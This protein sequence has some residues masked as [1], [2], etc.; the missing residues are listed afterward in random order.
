[1]K[2][3]AFA[4]LGGFAAQAKLG[5]VSL[6]HSQ[7]KEMN[8]GPCDYGDDRGGWGPD[9]AWN[10]STS[11]CPGQFGPSCTTCPNSW[12][13]ESG[14]AG[15]GIPRECSG[16]GTCDGSG[17]LGGTGVCTCAPGYSGGGCELGPPPATVDGP[18]G[19]CPGGITNGTCC[20]CT[21]G[22]GTRC[23]GYHGSATWNKAGFKGKVCCGTRCYTEPDC[24]VGL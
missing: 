20:A 23:L 17:T 14:M 18:N 13:I 1:M 22:Y 19:A 7:V 5:K 12:V 21:Q 4:L 9:S 2:L 24:G 11:C 10:N 6:K 3:V 16:H 8:P 15:I